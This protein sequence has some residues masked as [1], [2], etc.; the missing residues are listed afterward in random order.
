MKYIIELS[1]KR[2]I[3]IDQDELLDVMKGVAAKVPVIVRQGIFNPSFFVSI[4]EDEE[5]GPV[6][7]PDYSIPRAVDDYGPPRL[8]YTECPNLPD[9][10]KDVL[11]DMEQLQ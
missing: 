10:F 7:L 11:K 8:K 6:G 4:V 9:I 1:N 5:R 3:P 2:Q